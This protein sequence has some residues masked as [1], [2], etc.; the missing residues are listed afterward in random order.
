VKLFSPP[1]F[2]RSL[3]PPSPL[4]PFPPHITTYGLYF[5]QRMPFNDERMVPFPSSASCLLFAHQY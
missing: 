1:S 5:C 4:F 2:L 3:L